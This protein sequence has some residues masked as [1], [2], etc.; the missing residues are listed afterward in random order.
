MLGEISRPDDW[1]IDHEMI[2]RND[3]YR[4]WAVLPKYK[5][6]PVLVFVK[7]L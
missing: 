7:I 6:F 5:L 4:Q 1:D 3:F 2:D